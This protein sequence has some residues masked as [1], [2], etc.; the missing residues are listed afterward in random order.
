[1]L[2]SKDPLA[3]IDFE[4]SFGFDIRLG[5]RGWLEANVKSTPLALNVG[6]PKPAATAAE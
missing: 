6:S 3:N 2:E 5:V 4:W 1:M